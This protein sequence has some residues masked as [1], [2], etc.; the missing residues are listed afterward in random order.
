MLGR[1]VAQW[2]KEPKEGMTEKKSLNFLKAVSREEKEANTY[3]VRRKSE[4][5]WGGIDWEV[6]STMG[7]RRKE[8]KGGIVRYVY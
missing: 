3:L 7:S 1:T 4:M 6:G 5:E 2:R 8:K